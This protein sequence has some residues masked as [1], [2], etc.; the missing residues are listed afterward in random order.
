MDNKDKWVMGI[1]TSK[2]E[3][4][5]LSMFKTIIHLCLEYIYASEDKLKK[6]L[7][8]LHMVHNDFR[9]K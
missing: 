9:K 1:T 2:T 7:Q 3:N 5:T 6:G 4:T 8:E